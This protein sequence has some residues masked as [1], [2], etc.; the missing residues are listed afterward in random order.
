MVTHKKGRSGL[1]HQLPKKEGR[2]GPQPQVADTSQIGSRPLLS[3]KAHLEASK[4]WL[5]PLKRKPNIC[6]QN[7][8]P[9]LQFLIST[10]PPQSLPPSK[11]TFPCLNTLWV[12]ILEFSS[13]PQQSSQHH[14]PLKKG[15]WPLQYQL[16]CLLTHIFDFLTLF[17]V[18]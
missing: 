9:H 14:F 17:L 12:L 11:I 5:K 15:M 7:A 3:K 18:L 4:V 6:Q 8:A 13:A 10:W 1:C 16:L 2:S